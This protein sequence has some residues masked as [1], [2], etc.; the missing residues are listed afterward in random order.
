[1]TDGAP[2]LDGSD[3][4]VPTPKRVFFTYHVYA[5][6][7]FNGLAGADTLCQ[8]AATSIGLGAQ[9]R[10]WLSSEV[11]TASARLTHSAGPYVT[12][13][14]V[15]V[16]ASWAELTSGSLR[17]AIDQTEMGPVP[18]TGSACGFGAV[19]TGTLTNGSTDPGATCDGWSTTSGNATLGYSIG[20]NNSWTSACSGVCAGTASLYC[21]EQ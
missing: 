16:A 3:G 13:N 11:D 8:S 19:W 7:A 17:H 20:K 5:I 1:M 9:F 6:S 18:Q 12:L 10:A 21:I 14:N 2:A 4:A 15:L